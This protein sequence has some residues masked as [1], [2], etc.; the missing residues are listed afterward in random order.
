MIT[1]MIS[2]ASRGLGL[3]LVERVLELQNTRVIAAARNPGKSEEL[4]T[5]AKD[6]PDRLTLL[7]LDTS[8][9]S[10]IKVCSMR[11]VLHSDNNEP[12]SPSLC[13]GQKL[14]DYMYCSGGCLAPGADSP[15][16]H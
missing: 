6:S 5:L 16:R 4:Q 15:T 8:V 10:S 9:E 7:T 1:Y 12:L 2:G 3:G 11:T 13:Q 14:K